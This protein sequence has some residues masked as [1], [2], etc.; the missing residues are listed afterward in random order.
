MYRYICIDFGYLSV[1]VSSTGL[2][3]SIGP[4]LNWLELVP[5]PRLRE[6]EHVS[7]HLSCF[8]SSSPQHLICFS[9]HVLS[10]APCRSEAFAQALLWAHDTVSGL[11][12]HGSQARTEGHGPITLSRPNPLR[13][14]P[15]WQR[16]TTKW[17]KT[18]HRAWAISYL[19]IGNVMYR[20]LMPRSNFFAQYIFI[21][22][23]IYKYI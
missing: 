3:F 23:S 19:F 13:T 6:W 1:I 15:A 12:Y 2:I 5:I 16:S 10:Q 21:I 11:V 14:G 9:C 7:L 8:L 20:G 22:Y 17:I 18:L 4:Q